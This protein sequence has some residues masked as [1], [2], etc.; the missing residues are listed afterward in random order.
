MKKIVYLFLLTFTITCTNSKQDVTPQ[1]KAESTSKIT[2]QD[3]VKTIIDK[4]CNS[5][6]SNKSHS[7]GVKLEDLSD[8]QFWA[9]SGEL[10]DQII[11]FGGNPPRMPKGIPLTNCEV[12]TIKKWIDGGMN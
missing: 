1:C 11:P 4:N 7:G 5:C 2:Y 8:L 9:N 12:L 3:D 6:H 10:Y